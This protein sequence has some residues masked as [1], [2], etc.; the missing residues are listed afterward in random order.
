VAIHPVTGE[1]ILYLSEGFCLSLSDKA[2]NE[3]DPSVLHRLLE[4][5]GQLDETFAT[6]G[7]YLQTYEKGDLLVWDNRSL[8]H[9]A[10]HT[11]K[12]EPAASFRVTVHDEYPFDAAAAN[13]A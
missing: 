4:G 9:R 5:S 13:A 8:I 6:A 11:T 1:R 10:L 7:T 2:G 12:P 3:L